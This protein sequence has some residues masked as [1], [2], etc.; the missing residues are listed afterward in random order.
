MTLTDYM[1]QAKKNGSEGL[2]SIKNSVDASIEQL[3]DYIQKHG[4]ILIRAT[5]NNTDITRTNRTK[6]NQK[7]KIGR[8]ATLW[9]F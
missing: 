9:A 1:T 4:G 2:D 6:N 5:R 8:K 7:T 3:E